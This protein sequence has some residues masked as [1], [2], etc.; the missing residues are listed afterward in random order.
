M[1]M[2]GAH[3]EREDFAKSPRRDV[4]DTFHMKNALLSLG[5]SINLKKRWCNHFGGG[6]GGGGGGEPTHLIEPCLG[7]WL[8]VGLEPRNT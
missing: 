7:L 3:S 5:S 4:I 8:G 6:G 2:G 1:C